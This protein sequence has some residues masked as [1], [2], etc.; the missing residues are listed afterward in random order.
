MAATA[1]RDG[2][3]GPLPEKSERSKR[4]EGSS[5]HISRSRRQSVH[6]LVVPSDGLPSDVVSFDA[7]T[8]S[9][10]LR[11]DASLYPLGALYGAAYVFD[12]CYV[13]LDRE[14]DAGSP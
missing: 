12:R 1:P 4:K 8:S 10:T 3:R 9:V 13:L 2:T 14:G 6:S 11:V 7:S 5:R